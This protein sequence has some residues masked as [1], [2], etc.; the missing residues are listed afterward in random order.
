MSTLRHY[1]LNALS[2]HFMLG[3]R[4]YTTLLPSSSDCAIG[5]KQKKKESFIDRL[6]LREVVLPE[7]I[8]H[9][10]REGLTVNLA[11]MNDKAKGFM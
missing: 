7:K 10:V 6:K 11:A 5:K 3:I 8:R 2:Y 9:V 4:K 1:S